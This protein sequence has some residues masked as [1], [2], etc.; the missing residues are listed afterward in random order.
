[1]A[2]TP[3][4]ERAPFPRHRRQDVQYE[5]AESAVHGVIVDESGDSHAA[6]EA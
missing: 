5:W 6:L 3:A 2:S 4:S 1:M